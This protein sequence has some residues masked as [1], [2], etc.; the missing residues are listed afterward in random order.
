M[1]LKQK[2]RV[3]FLRC[4]AT[5]ATCPGAGRQRAEHAKMKQLLKASLQAKH[6][7]PCRLQQ[8]RMTIRLKTLWSRELVNSWSNEFG[9]SH[10]YAAEA[11][12][13]S[14]VSPLCNYLSNLTRCRET[15][16]WTCQNE[17]AVKSS[18]SGERWISS[19]ITAETS[20]HIFQ[21]L[22]TSWTRE[23]VN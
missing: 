5:W 23:L 19:Q 1:Q 14:N 13:S 22:A 18:S 2:S 12:I 9:E 20:D 10:D 4:V 6:E 8:K 11:G 7:S 15:E 3:K 17:A 21:N 16:S